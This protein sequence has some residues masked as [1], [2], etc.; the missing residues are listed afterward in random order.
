MKRSFNPNPIVHVTRMFLVALAI[1]A[2]LIFG[3]KFIPEDIIMKVLLVIWV[4]AVIY[5]A[6]ANIMVKFRTISLHENALN[7]R[8]G[9]LSSKKVVLPYVKI[10]EATY[11]QSFVQRIFRVG[12]LKIDSAGGS[13]AAIFVHDVNTKDL[14]EILEEI[15]AKT[16][17]GSK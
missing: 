15:N 16:G 1:S 6:L 8:E 10:T 7:Y 2:L 5:I 13:F 12:T 17:K 4:L 3:M 11:V 9:I 14:D